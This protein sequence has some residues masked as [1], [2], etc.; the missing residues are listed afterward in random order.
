[1]TRNDK[2]EIMALELYRC[3]QMTMDACRRWMARALD[4]LEQ[5]IEDEIDDEITRAGMHH[6]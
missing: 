2:V 1:M 5:A 3:Q 4:A 6:A